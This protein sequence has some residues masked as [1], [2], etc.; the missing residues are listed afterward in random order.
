M[1]LYILISHH[2]GPAVS[3]GGQYSHR[4]K[5]G[6]RKLLSLKRP[7]GYHCFTLFPSEVSEPRTLALNWRIPSLGLPDK[8]AAATWAE[9][10]QAGPFSGSF[11]LASVCLSSPC[12]QLRSSCAGV[13][14]G[15]VTLAILCTPSY[16]SQASSQRRTLRKHP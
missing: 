10:R 5:T 15:K 3:P 14:A 13:D 16:D 7:C 8:T 9:S 12:T 11:S 1:P 2:S 6:N 4:L